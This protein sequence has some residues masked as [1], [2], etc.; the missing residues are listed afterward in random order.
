MR[1]EGNRIRIKRMYVCRNS[2]DQESS[3]DAGVCPECGSKMLY[4]W[5]MFMG[6]TLVYQLGRNLRISNRTGEI[7][8]QEGHVEEADVDDLVDFIDAVFHDRWN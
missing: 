5:G 6:C 3:E 1:Y 8:G 7:R 4:T 2:C